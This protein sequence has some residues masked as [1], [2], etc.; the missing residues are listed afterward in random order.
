MNQS[1]SKITWDH[2]NPYSPSLGTEKYCRFTWKNK[3]TQGVPSWCKEQKY[4]S[5]RQR[6]KGHLQGRQGNS[7]TSGN[8][9]VSEG[10]TPKSS[11]SKR[12]SSTNPRFL[13][14]NA[15]KPPCFR[16]INFRTSGPKEDI[17]KIDG[18]WEDTSNMKNQKTLDQLIVPETAGSRVPQ[19]FYYHEAVL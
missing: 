7:P 14:D 9:H 3:S 8:L 15:Y 11:V 5:I 4:Y 16:N 10:S 17:S 12:T 2:V 13:G 19:R 6:Y 1:G 18:F